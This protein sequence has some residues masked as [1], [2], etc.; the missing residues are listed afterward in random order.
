[1]GIAALLSKFEAA[2]AFPE[3]MR[4]LIAAQLELYA[5]VAIIFASII[6]GFPSTKATVVSAHSGSAIK[7]LILIIMFKKKTKQKQNS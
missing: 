4:A 1:L 5:L 2:Q 6:G 3:L 7:M